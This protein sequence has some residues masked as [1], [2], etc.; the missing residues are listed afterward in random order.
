M[1]SLGFLQATSLV[2]EIFLP[3]QCLNLLFEVNDIVI[4]RLDIMRL[5]RHLVNR[6]WESVGTGKRAGFAWKEYLRQAGKL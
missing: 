2:P 1:Q 6:R 4:Y 5:I 3:F